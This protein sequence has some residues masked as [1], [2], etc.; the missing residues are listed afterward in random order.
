M[1]KIYLLFISVIF[2]LAIASVSASED[3]ADV[4][5]AG[6]DSS[7]SAADSQPALEK[8]HYYDANGKKYD[9]D[10]VVT[11]DVEKYYGDDSTKFK[12]KVYDGNKKPQGNV[13]V[14]FGESGSKLKQK[15]TNANGNV[16]F[17]IDYSV[18]KHKV[19]T[20][21]NAKDGKSFWLAKN[22]VTIKSTIPTKKI[23]K[24]SDDTKKSKV[25][26]LDTKGKALKK[27]TVTFKINKKTYKVKTDKKGVAKLKAKWFKEGIQKITAYNPV[28]GEKKKI[29]VTVL[30]KG[31]QTVKVRV[32]GS[33][34]EM[35]VVKLKNGDSLSTVYETQN[36][37]YSAGVHLESFYKGASPAKH[38]KL[39]KAKFYF[40]NK[41]T[42]ET[43][44]KTSKEVNA[45]AISIPPVDG[46]T[47][48]KV[49]VW[50]EDVK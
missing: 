42:G 9:D 13:Y 14:N 47:P 33:S 46:Y 22:T 41:K 50:Y 32:D 27:K 11:K 8:T 26:F 31:V 12:V 2:L 18:G 34:K 1:R 5:Q 17:A 24:F 30:K 39:V 28:S 29:T 45:G 44:T 48:F 20:R 6:E 15:T 49:K 23:V 37:Q 38:T 19:V 25:Q 7:L 36:K 16:K 43:I 21:I 4:L 35:P 10:T 3:A 40:K